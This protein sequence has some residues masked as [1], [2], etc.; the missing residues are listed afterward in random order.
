MNTKIW[1]IKN[2]GKVDNI[3]DALLTSRGIKTES[4]KKEFFNPKDPNKI[5]IK[6]TGIDPQ[7][8]KKG[9]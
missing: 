6:E 2:K 7:E 8:V 1:E 5:S 9:N 3:I 4:E